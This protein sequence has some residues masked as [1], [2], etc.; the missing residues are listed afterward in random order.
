MPSGKLNLSGPIDK[1][2]YIIEIEIFPYSDEE[3][4]NHNNKTN[5]NGQQY[6]VG[7]ITFKQNGISQPFTDMDVANTYLKQLFGT[8]EMYKEIAGW[9]GKIFDIG[10]YNA[11]M[12]KLFKSDKTQIVFKPTVF[13]G[14]KRRKRKSRRNRRSKKYQR[15]HNKRKTRKYI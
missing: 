13:T 7:A 12:D 1:D 10:K 6:K 3:D 15:R 9:S 4:K 5:E 2:D 8:A 14:G 11:T